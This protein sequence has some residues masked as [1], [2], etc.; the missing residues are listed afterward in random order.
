MF[1]VEW[2][3]EAERDLE[4]I[5]IFYLEPAGHGVAESVYSRIMERV[6]SVDKFPE[7]ARPGRVLGTREFVVSRLSY[8]ATVHVGD[9]AVTVLNLIHTARKYPADHSGT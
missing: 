6:G 7:R 4:D 9:G 8:V 2:T 5:L 1:K 3:D